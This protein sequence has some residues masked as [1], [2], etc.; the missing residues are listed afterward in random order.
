M[1]GGIPTLLDIDVGC[2]PPAVDVPDGPLPGRLLGTD[3]EILVWIEA[4]RL[5]GL[6]YAWWCDGRAPTSM[7]AVDGLRFDT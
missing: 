2:S 3:G 6:E 1:V 7:P 4:G 5:N